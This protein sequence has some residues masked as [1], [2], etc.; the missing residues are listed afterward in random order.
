VGGEVASLGSTLGQPNFTI[1]AGFDLG[2]HNGVGPLGGAQVGYN[3]QFPGSPIVIGLEGEFS[4]ANLKGN[5][6]SPK[7]ALRMG[8]VRSIAGCSGRNRAV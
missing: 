3:F 5:N 1:S 2:S 6:H 4:F 8:G 7:G